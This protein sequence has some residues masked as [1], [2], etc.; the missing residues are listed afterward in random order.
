M[1]TVGVVSYYALGE[2]ESVTRAEKL[3]C[4]APRTRLWRVMAALGSPVV[5]E[6]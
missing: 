3:T 4:A 2:V 6:V 1:D 5:P